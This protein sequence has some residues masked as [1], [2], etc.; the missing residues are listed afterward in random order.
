MDWE[1]HRAGVF[2]Q[3]APVGRPSGRLAGVGHLLENH[4]LGE[5]LKV[6]VDGHSE[7]LGRSLREGTVMDAGIVAAAPST[8][9]RS[10]TTSC[11]TRRGSATAHWLAHPPRRQ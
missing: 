8:N 6:V 4:A 9:S 5:G 7:S 1:A 11:L 2:R 10:C 3:N